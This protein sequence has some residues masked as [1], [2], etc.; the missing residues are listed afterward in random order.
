MG[1]VQYLSQMFYH[2][3]LKFSEFFS[4]HF[5]SF[6][7]GVF[8]PVIYVGVTANVM[9]VAINALLIDGVGLVFQYVNI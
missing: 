8:K 2:V 3:P 7:Q 5:F 6:L 4:L 9:H 1:E